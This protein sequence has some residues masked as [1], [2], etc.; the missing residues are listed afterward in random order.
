MEKSS[1]GGGQSVKVS[2]LEASA[3]AFL[4]RVQLKDP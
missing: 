3:I 2:D 1:V 4:V